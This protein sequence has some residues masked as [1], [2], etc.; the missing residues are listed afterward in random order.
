M[1][2]IKYDK[3]YIFFLIIKPKVQYVIKRNDK[4]LFLLEHQWYV[5]L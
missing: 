5:I 2:Y 3:K 1:K 4:I